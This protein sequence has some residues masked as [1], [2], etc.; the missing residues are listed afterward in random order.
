MAVGL[1]RASSFALTREITPGEYVAPTLG[2][3]FV[4]LRPGNELSYE[5]E[6]LDSDELLNDIGAAKS[7]VGKESVS[8]THA[9][10]LRHSGVEGQEPQLGILFESILGTKHVAVAEYATIV[11]STT[12]ILKVGSGI[13]ANFVEGQAVLVKSGVGYEIRN[14]DSINGDDLILNFALKNAPGTGI[15]LGKVI[16][17]IPAAQGHP[18]F[19]TTKYVGGGFAK[20]VSA[21]DTVTEL[22]I[23]ADAN[24]FAEVEF[25]FEGTRYYFNPIIIT[26]T[27]KFLDVTDDS[28]AV[29]IQIAEGIYKTPV[30]LADALHAAANAASTEDYTITYSNADGKFKIASTSTVLTLNWNTGPNAANSIGTK[31]GFLVAADDSGFLT[32]TSDN[33]Q[34][35]N[36]PVTPVYDTADAII[37]KNAELFVGNV[38]DNSCICAQTVKIT[39]S[40]T[41]EDVDCICE[42]TGVL[43]KIPTAREVT[44]EIASVLKKYDASLLDALLKNSGISA[45]LNCGPKAGGNWVPGKCFNTY[46]QKC[47]VNSYKTQGDSFVQAGFT[48]KG[49]VTSTEKDIFI[50]F[51]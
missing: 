27:S 3:Q 45:M 17:Y 12:K 48:L 24:G 34:T 49:Y 29:A 22:S 46:F 41:V 25:S 11:G 36:A 7:F 5:P 32:Y 50:N 33:A 26:A 38:D 23:T 14:I 42:E 16:T 35:Y 13:G 6:A 47:T 19:S 51:V 18:T 4:P 40:K 21:G 9:A 44:A 28:G 43:E 31:I 20:E 37:I 10:Y 39:A 15:N 30:E 1:N 8:G 2:N